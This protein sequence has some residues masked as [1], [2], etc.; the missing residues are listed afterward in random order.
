M[1]LLGH[2]KDMADRKAAIDP[3]QALRLD[4]VLVSGG[5]CTGGLVSIFDDGLSV[6]DGNRISYIPLTG[7]AS[8]SFDGP[9]FA[10]EPPPD[11]GGKGK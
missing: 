5:T 10:P 11:E 8:L 7:M 2:F 4:I 3:G 1:A 6:M 9:V